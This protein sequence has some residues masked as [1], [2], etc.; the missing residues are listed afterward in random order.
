MKKISFTLLLAGSMCHTIFAQD[1]NRKDLSSFDIGQV[2]SIF[3]TSKDIGVLTAS[4]T[5]GNQYM[6][7]ILRT[8][9]GGNTW[10]IV[11]TSEVATYTDIHFF[12]EENGIIVGY[13]ENTGIGSWQCTTADGGKNWDCNYILGSHNH[14]SELLFLDDSVG[15]AIAGNSYHPLLRSTN[16]GQTWDAISFSGNNSYILGIDFPSNNIG[17]LAGAHYHPGSPYWGDLYKSTNAGADWELIYQDSTQPFSKIKFF[18]EGNGLLFTTLNLWS[19]S[20]GGCMI[21]KTQDGGFTWQQVTATPL[22]QDVTD[23]FLSE[24]GLVYA[25]GN[26]DLLTGGVILK[27]EDYGE[28]WATSLVVPNNNF[29]LSKAHHNRFRNRL[30]IGAYDGYYTLD[31]VLS[32]TEQQPVNSDEFQLYPNPVQGLLNVEVKNAGEWNLEVFNSYGQRAFSSTINQSGQVLDLQY[33]PMGSYFAIMA[34]AEGRVV[35]RKFILVGN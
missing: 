14:S 15:F 1:W 23:V 28:H 12:D 19:A 21:K 26:G 10:S 13:H 6:G 24:N 22:L 25:I 33:L 2:T 8:E 20:N 4:K 17:Y 32:A 7:Y 29:T 34:N 3:F 35:C 9:N 18:D 11:N 31:N 5:V 16:K 30:Y 27:S